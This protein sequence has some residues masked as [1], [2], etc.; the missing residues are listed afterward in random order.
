MGKS[1]LL[2]A[3]WHRVVPASAP[4]IT[5]QNAPYSQPYTLDDTVGFHSLNEVCRATGLKTASAIWSTEYMQRFADE[6]FV[7]QDRQND[8][9]LQHPGWFSW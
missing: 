7:E 5:A 8:E 1:L 3:G 4:G 9:S 6:P 2:A